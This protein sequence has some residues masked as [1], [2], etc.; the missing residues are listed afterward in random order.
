MSI[1]SN[2]SD[3]RRVR[4]SWIVFCTGLDDEKKLNLGGVGAGLVESTSGEVGCVDIPTI[5]GAEL[6]VNHELNPPFPMPLKTASLSPVKD[7]MSSSSTD[8]FLSFTSF[9]G[10]VSLDFGLPNGNN[11]VRDRC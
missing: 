11:A 3:S 6:P 2:S 10:L 4:G 5:N 7:A 9:F 8:R 1:V